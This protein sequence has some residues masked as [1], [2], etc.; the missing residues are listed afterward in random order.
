MDIEVRRL[1]TM[2][3]REILPVH[4]GIGIGTYDSQLGMRKR[5][6]VESSYPYLNGPCTCTVKVGVGQSEAIP[7][8]HVHAPQSGDIK[9]P[10][11]TYTAA[12]PLR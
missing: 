3:E 6:K 8:V 1:V 10:T 5:G 4:V 2:R 7:C 12:P 11:C 9:V